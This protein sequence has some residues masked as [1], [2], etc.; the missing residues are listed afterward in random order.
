MP[1]QNTELEPRNPGR[2]MHAPSHRLAPSCRIFGNTGSCHGAPLLPST[3]YSPLLSAAP[4]H[5][6]ATHPPNPLR[7]RPF[8]PTAE[9]TKR[10]VKGAGDIMTA[11]LLTILLI[12]DGEIGQR[13]TSC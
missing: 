1:P 6:V 3:G 7:G 13:P 4:A 8:H 10:I 2:D 9:N 11:Q 12:E 5:A